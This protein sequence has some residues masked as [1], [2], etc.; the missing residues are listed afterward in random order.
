[1]T[2]IALLLC[3]LL[4]PARPPQAPRA[5]LATFYAPGVMAE[6]VA[7]RAGIGQLAPCPDCLGYVALLEPA[8]IGARVWLRRPGAAIEGP[9][10]VADC[11]QRAHRDRLTRLG[12]V[13]D[14]DWPTAQRWGMAGPLTAVQ[15]W[16]AAPDA[17]VADAE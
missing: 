12:W 15:V 1:M 5:G 13:V 2:T 11:A 6:V 7:Y 4:A 8:H 16:F 10:L 9:Y 14:V 17:E 3:L